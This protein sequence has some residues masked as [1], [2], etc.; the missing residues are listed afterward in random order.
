MGS[1]EAAQIRLRGLYCLLSISLQLPHSWR[2]VGNLSWLLWL[3]FALHGVLGAA[4]GLSVDEAHYLLYAAH[5]ALS[6]FD[7]PPLVGWVQWPL[8]ALQAPVWLLRLLPGLLW[9]LT[10]VGVY[11]LSLQWFAAQPHRPDAPSAQS[12][13]QWAVVAMLLAPL[14][15]VLGIGLLPDT[16]LMALTVGLMAQTWRL[17]QRGALATWADWLLLGALVGLAGL[18]KYTAVFTALALALCLFYALRG[19]LLRAPTV[20]RAGVAVVLAAVLVLPVFAWNAQHQWVSFAYQVAHGQGSVWQWQHLLR[21]ALTQLLAYGPL[22]CLGWWGW[23]ASAPAQ[24]WMGSFFALP[25]LVLA[26]LSGGGSS[27]PH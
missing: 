27:L 7:H 20:A 2:P 8:V 15:H 10:V 9:L 13:A 25:M 17:M 19:Q 5:P 16:L 23:R 3:A 21:F 1:G 12:A 14:L 24:R 6:Y 11:R 26:Y 22:L 18:A 4:M